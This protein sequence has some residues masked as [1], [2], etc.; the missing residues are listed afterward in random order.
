MYKLLFQILFVG[1]LVVPTS[2]L[3]QFKIS[4]QVV[5]SKS[6]EV[7]YVKVFLKDTIGITQDAFVTDSLGKFILYSEKEGV[8]D[9]TVTSFDSILFRRK[10]IVSS[11]VNL[12]QVQLPK[13]SLFDE[14]TVKSTRPKLKKELGKYVVDDVYQSEFARGKSSLEFLSFVPIISTSESDN[15]LKILNNTSAQIFINGKRV[16]DAQVAIAML[17]SIP[18]ENI[19][20]IEIINN[21]DSRFDA[22][23]AG[24]II[25]IIL[26]RDKRDG[27]RGTIT[28]SDRQSFYNSPNMKG[29]LSVSKGK[30][31]I[32]SGLS[33]NRNFYRYDSDSY[34]LDRLTQT[35][36]SIDIHS[37]SRQDDGLLFVNS[38]Y[39][40]STKSTIEL[41]TNLSINTFN[42]EYLT[43][44]EIVQNNNYVI[45]HSSINETPE[46]NNYKNRNILS[47]SYKND[48]SG[49]SYS[50]LV[51]YY[52]RKLSSQKDFNNEYSSSLLPFTFR[53]ISDI[54]TEILNIKFDGSKRSNKGNKLSFGASFISSGIDND[55]ENQNVAGSSFVIDTLLSNRFLYH[56]QILGIYGAYDFNIGE[57]FEST[58]GSRVEQFN[59][60]GEVKQN[61][62]IATLS[63]IYLFPSASIFYMFNDD[64][65][66]SLEY[67]RHITRPQYSYLNPFITYTSANSFRQNNINIR[68][69]LSDEI[70]LD[71]SFFGD[72][73]V[74]F[75]Y[76]HDKNLF[77][78][79]EIVLDSNWVK[80]TVDNYGNSNEFYSN[81]TYSRT[82]FKGRWNISLIANLAHETTTAEYN[83][84]DLSFKNTNYSAFAR[85]QLIL[86]KNRGFY[87][88]MSYGYLS[89]NR[90]IFGTL[91]QQNSF[92]LGMKQTLKN[93]TFSL[94]LYDLARSTL[95][96]N[97][98]NTS[99]EFSKT[100]NYYKTIM[101]SVGYSFGNKNVKKINGKEDDNINN[102]LL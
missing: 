17:N 50:G 5:D 83:D 37:K 78:D 69:T 35:T 61:T 32:T 47:Y 90:A 34:Y 30:F 18:A 14:V 57:K 23:T 96:I 67:S 102:R 82:F 70:T 33:L 22:G 49:M 55:F 54:S 85:S 52:N 45:N 10:L 89:S 25:N 65:E 62:E 29:F 91:N 99:Y 16:E 41:Q 38:S 19:E 97:Q 48:S 7:P 79:F 36:S 42:R 59:F 75:E 81:F 21:P 27:V 80:S 2:V 20:K 44:S 40:L 74:L 87:L 28:L 77:N 53:Q 92:E 100:I 84:V 101:M 11:N 12:G 66:V 13:F 15:S 46:N 60:R 51:G 8:F 64:H 58:I 72:F 24:G 68:P 63:S 31:N 9:L 3:S 1:V 43:T 94:N 93:W 98:Q 56:D 73:F 39:Q 26:Y 6:T 86:G 76:A 71:Y 95:V 4:G 88:L